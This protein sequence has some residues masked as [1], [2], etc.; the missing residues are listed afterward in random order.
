MT[1]GQDRRVGHGRG[2]ARV[3]AVCGAPPR[4]RPLRHRGLPAPRARARRH[5]HPALAAR[6]SSRTRCARCRAPRPDG[7]PSPARRVTRASAG[8][9]PA[10]SAAD[11]SR[12]Q[13]SDVVAGSGSRSDTNAT[14]LPSGE[15]LPCHSSASFGVSF[16]ASP[17]SVGSNDE[18][19]P[20]ALR[21][22]MRKDDATV[23]RPGRPALVAGHRGDAARR[24]A[25]GGR[26]PEVELA[27]LLGA[28]RDRLAVGRPRGIALDGAVL[29][30]S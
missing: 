9:H 22:A 17:G 26:D 3:A 13:M 29:L 21:R 23:V 5:P 16:V 14:S 10:A 28:E 24:A 30:A 25:R 2:R 11:S 12:T 1:R 8:S 4:P 20:R 6:A 15:T 19:L 27:V 7:L 18:Q